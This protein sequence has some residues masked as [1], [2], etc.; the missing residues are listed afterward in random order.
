MQLFT[1]KKGILI[2][3]FVGFILS[4]GD[5][6]QGQKDFDHPSYVSKTGGRFKRD[7]SLLDRKYCGNNITLDQPKTR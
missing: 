3:N 6:D 7:A 1:L 2:L 5:V 4:C